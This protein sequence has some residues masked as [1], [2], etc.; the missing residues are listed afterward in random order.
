MWESQHLTTLWAF[1]ACYRDGFYHVSKELKIY[2]LNMPA[3]M[4]GW[5]LLHLKN[6][7]AIRQEDKNCKKF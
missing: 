7:C 4:L 1:T 6:T 3:P 2:L 5:Q